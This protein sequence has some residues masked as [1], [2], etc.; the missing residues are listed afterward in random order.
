MK[1]VD[2]S[3]IDKDDES[4]SGLNNILQ[5]YNNIATTITIP[6]LSFFCI[7]S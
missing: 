6:N 7:F 5:W 4:H 3:C 2:V 1:N